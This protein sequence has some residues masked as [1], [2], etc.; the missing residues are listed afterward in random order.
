M[1]LSALLSALGVAILFA[2]GFAVVVPRAP[3]GYV[4]LLT[5]GTFGAG[6]FYGTPTAR[7][8]AYPWR[9]LHTWRPVAAWA[10]TQSLARFLSRIGWTGLL[11]RSISSP[12]DLPTL[13]RQ[14]VSALLSHAVSL[15]F[16]LV[17]SGALLVASHWGW[18]LGCLGLGAL[19]HGWPCLL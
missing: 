6:L 2:W 8:L 3:G 15:V 5:I 12:G 4:A 11:G 18:T 17:A 19:V 13:R 9:N 14:A 1:K 10:R 7:V 16:H